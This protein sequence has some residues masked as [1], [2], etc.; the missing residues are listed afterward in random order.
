MR[1]GDPTFAYGVAEAETAGHIVLRMADAPVLPLQFGGL[2]DTLGAYLEELRKLVEEKRSQSEELSR[3][4]DGNAFALA[5]DPTRVVA[6]PQREGPVAAVEF[7][8]LR[9]RR[10]R[11]SQGARRLT[12]RRTRS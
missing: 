5:A 10:R 8:P 11:G 1:F 12:M 7:A 2:A 3:L 4:L 6:P 9:E